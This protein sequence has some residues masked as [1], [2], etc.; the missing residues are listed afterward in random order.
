M[1]SSTGGVFGGP[2]ENSAASESAA[3]GWLAL[4]VSDALFTPVSSALIGHPPPQR[5]SSPVWIAHT[6]PHNARQTRHSSAAIRSHTWHRRGG[7]RPAAG[8]SR[9]WN[10]AFWAEPW[11]RGRTP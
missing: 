6:P 1:P 8:T 9:R 10:F 5:A 4:V 7:R 2:L 3:S 11:H